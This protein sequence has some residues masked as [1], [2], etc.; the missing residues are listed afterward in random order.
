MS[1]RHQR[2]LDERVDAELVLNAHLL[3]MLTAGASPDLCARVAELWFAAV[4]DHCRRGLAVV[5]PGFVVGWPDPLLLE[6][7]HHARLARGGAGRNKDATCDDLPDGSD[8]RPDHVAALV[9]ERVS[10]ALGGSHGASRVAGWP[11]IDPRIVTAL[12]LGHGPI[13]VVIEVVIALEGF[14]AAFASALRIGDAVAIDTRSPG[15]AP[16]RR[17][18]A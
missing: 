4:S 9:H 3:S 15:I 5:L 14:I 6:V 7:A 11:A 17:A 10:A 2:P 18:A 16:E 12:G 13:D 1:D 8:I